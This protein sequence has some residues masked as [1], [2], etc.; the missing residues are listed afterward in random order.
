MIPRIAAKRQQRS[1]DS[2]PFNNI[3]CGIPGNKILKKMQRLSSIFDQ[4][5]NY[6]YPG[7]KTANKVK[8]IAISTNGVIDITT[9]TIEMNVVS[10]RNTRC[11]DPLFRFTLSW[12]E[13]EHPDPDDIFDAAKHAIKSIGLADHQYILV[14]HGN[15]LNTHC[16]ITINRIHP[17]TFRSHNIKWS[18][19]TLHLAARESEIKHGWANENGI[20]I[21][22]IDKTNQKRIVMNQKHANH[23]AEEMLPHE[24]II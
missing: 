22:E 20:Y 8:C 17:E 1:S 9:A 15:I 5:Q 16:H 14:V 4:I 2:Q 6:V 10:S 24:K 19:T 3:I 12:P 11:L 13:N 21:V 23:I 18:I 7:Y